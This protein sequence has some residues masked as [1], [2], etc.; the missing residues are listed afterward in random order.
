MEKYVCDSKGCILGTVKKEWDDKIIFYGKRNERLGYYDGKTDQTYDF[1]GNPI[2]EGN[3]IP[4]LLYYPRQLKFPLPSIQEV[5]FTTY[6]IKRFACNPKNGNLSS[7]YW[8]DGRCQICTRKGRN[9][10]HVQGLPG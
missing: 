2:G 5:S 9:T 4:D 1:Y 10:C 6:Q 7:K 8:D 3:L